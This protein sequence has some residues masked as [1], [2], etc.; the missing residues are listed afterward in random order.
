MGAG[1]AGF[2]FLI[3]VRW[4]RSHSRCP[5]CFAGLA[6]LGLVLE[7]L[8]MKKQLFTGRKDEVRAAVYALQHLVLK[9]H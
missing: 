4:R 9:F 2:D 6:A 7:L 1:S 3:R 5:L 8:V